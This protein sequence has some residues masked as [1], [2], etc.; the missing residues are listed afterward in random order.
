[1]TRPQQMDDVIAAG[2]E[3]LGDQASVALPPQRLGAHEARVGF[4]EGRRERLRKVVAAHP[5]GVT[6]EGPDTDAVELCAAAAASSER[7]GMPVDD[8]CAFELTLERLAVELR[9]PP[10]PGKPADIDQRPDAGLGEARDELV[11]RPGAV[12]DREDAHGQFVHWH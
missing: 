10:R 4:R 3:Q 9:M 12:A 11:S 8:P 1:M 5:C 2:I 6:A 7:L